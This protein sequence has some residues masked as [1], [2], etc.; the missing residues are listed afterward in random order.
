[1]SEVIEYIKIA[2]PIFSA[3][4]IVVGV[5]FFVLNIKRDRIKQTLDYWEKINQQIK[6]DKQKLLKNYGEIISQEIVDLILNDNNEQIRI[7]RVINLYERLALGINIGVY[8]LKT[9]NRMVGQ[10]IIN[11]YA[12]FHLYIEARRKKLKRPFAWSEF[13]TLVNE[14]IKIRG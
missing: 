14:L 11:N 9:I 4:S 6:L 13:E 2:G 10:N 1:M 8:D 5:C 3:I 7:N 12:K